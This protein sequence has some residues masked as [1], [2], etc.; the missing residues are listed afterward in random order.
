[1]SSIGFLVKEK[2]KKIFKMAATV[3]ILDFQSEQFWLFLI[4]KSSQCFLP[5][6]KSVGL[7]VQEKKHKIDFQ[8]GRHSG[9]LG[10]RIR[11][12]LA[13]FDLQVTLM[14]PISFKSI[15]LLVQEKKQK[16]DFQ[17]GRHGSHLGF[18]IG[19]I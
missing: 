16:I 7:L 11:K 19:T 12:I 18:L 13:I 3:P 2:Q 6:S 5:S 9:H 8:D 1:M 4:Y 15:V 17:V 14:P 10:F